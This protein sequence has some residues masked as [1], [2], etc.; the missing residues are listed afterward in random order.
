ME[1]DGMSDESADIAGSESAS[2]VYIVY[3]Q[4]MKRKHAVRKHKGDIEHHRNKQNK[5][6]KVG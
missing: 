2:E 1:Y 3:K 5:W 6:G 4:R